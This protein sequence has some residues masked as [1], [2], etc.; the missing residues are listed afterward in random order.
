MDLTPCI[1][2]HANIVVTLPRSV[3]VNFVQTQRINVF[4]A[5]PGYAQYLRCL[6][7]DDGWNGQSILALL[8]CDKTKREI[9][10]HEDSVLSRASACQMSRC[11]D[12]DKHADTADERSPLTSFSEAN[13]ENSERNARMHA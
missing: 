7:R 3:P 8:V 10:Q 13:T 6:S 12:H 4:H 11:P 5:S 1:A 9:S 2:V